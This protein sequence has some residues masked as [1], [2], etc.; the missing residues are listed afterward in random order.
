M[1]SDVRVLRGGAVL[2]A[3]SARIRVLVVVLVLSVVAGGGWLIKV[4]DVDSGSGAN[5]YAYRGPH[6]AAHQH[7]VTPAQRREQTK[8]RV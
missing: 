5:D 8:D 6:P 7:A 3:V 1:T 2:T 4:A